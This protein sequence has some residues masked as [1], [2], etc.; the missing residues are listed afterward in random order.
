MTK[1]A[2]ANYVRGHIEQ[3]CNG[4]IINIDEDELLAEVASQLDD[5]C[6]PDTGATPI[7]QMLVSILD[8]VMEYPNIIDWKE[9][10]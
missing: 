4:E 1:T 6:D 3:N 2:L 9:L 7:D 5:E 10:D 8:K